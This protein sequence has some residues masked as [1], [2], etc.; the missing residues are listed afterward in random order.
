M[1][2]RVCIA[3]AILFDPRLIVA[4]ESTSALDV[5]SQRIVLQMLLKVRSHSGTSILLIGHDLA[6]QAQIADRI[7]ILFAGQ[8]VEIG[9]TQDI[10][11]NPR[12]PYTQQLIQSVP[13]IKYRTGIPDVP[14]STD[15][16]R[17]GWM[18][19]DEPLVEVSPGHFLRPVSETDMN[20]P[21]LEIREAGRTFRSGGREIVAV[22]SMSLSFP[23]DRP[24]LIT[25]AGESGC[26]KS[27]LA[28]MALGFL[29]PTRGQVL[30]RGQDLDHNGQDGFSGV[31][32]QCPSGVPESLRVVQ[33]VLSN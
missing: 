28:L 7:G 2:Q 1:K 20:A 30:Y 17:L 11:D 15:A 14:L 33:P 21:K 9:A 6:V 24:H 5:V 26:G 25:L 8:F 16:E 18:V 27:T 22:K 31:S 4:D 19:S 29:A 13:S 3:M 12:H 32:P 10:F 23:A